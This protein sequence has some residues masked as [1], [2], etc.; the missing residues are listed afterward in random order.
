MKINSISTQQYKYNNQQKG[1]KVNNSP[2]FKG[3]YETV[4]QSRPF[5]RLNGVVSR[6][7]K[8]FTYLMLAESCW[9]S[10]FYMLNTLMN[11][12][13]DK[14]QKPQM[15]INDALVLG[16]SSA[17][18]LFL[19]NKISGAYKKL[20]DKYFANPKNQ[21]FYKELGKKVQEQAGA[22]SAKN[23]LLA[24][25]ANGAEAVT[26]KLGDQLKGLVGKTGDLKAFEISA[27]QL[28]EL[29]G[30]VG[31]AVNANVGN[32][33]KAKKAVSGCVDDVYERLAA[34]NETDKIVPGI[35]KLK[36]VIIFGIIYRYIGPVVVTPL[37]NKI[38]S[39]FFNKKADNADKTQAT[40]E[41]K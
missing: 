26:T 13:I 27:D 29:Q 34:K 9:L 35:D 3:F 16:V 2:A 20:T 36:T 15:I 31:E 19:D 25:I 40:P 7:D 23:Q 33:R 8:T 21:Q 37:A 32:L 38:S 28:K 22:N 14:E 12:K 1:A 11:K 18:S 4:A 10:G 24:E 17:G 5:R 6:S 41:K 30:K 39:K